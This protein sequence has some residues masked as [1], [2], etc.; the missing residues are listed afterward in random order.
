MTQA[1][2]LAERDVLVHPI[3][4]GVIHKLQES[5]RHHV[6][7]MCYDCNCDPEYVVEEANGTKWLWCGY[8]DLG[9]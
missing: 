2:R 1:I 9:G 6:P 3:Q 5:H 8:C 4:D 7:G